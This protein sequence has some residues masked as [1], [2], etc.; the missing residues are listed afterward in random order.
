MGMQERTQLFGGNV[1]VKS[2]R[3]KGTKVIAFVPIG[4]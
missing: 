1:Y 3:G 4:N 2:E